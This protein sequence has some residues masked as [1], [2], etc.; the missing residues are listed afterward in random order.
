MGGAKVEY[1]ARA[2]ASRSLG[3][4]KESC[5]VPA[6]S[7]FLY[8]S[9]FLCIR[10]LLILWERHLSEWKLHSLLY[11]WGPRCLNVC[12]FCSVPDA[13]S[14]L[15]ECSVLPLCFHH[16][17]ITLLCFFVNKSPELHHVML[18]YLGPH[19]HLTC[20]CTPWI[21]RDLFSFSYNCCFFKVSSLQLIS[22]DN[23]TIRKVS[24]VV[25][26]L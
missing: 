1:V 12:L 2:M 21:V 17:W 6:V 5:A 13:S 19:L 22:N 7:L 15:V 4:I 3:C 10:L 16:F 24:L 23:V 11:S 9:I 14:S 26:N 20:N 8:M 25:I 18:L